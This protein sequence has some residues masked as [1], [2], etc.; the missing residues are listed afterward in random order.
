MAD[1]VYGQSDNMTVN[2]DGNNG[3]GEPG[4]PAPH[5]LSHP[6]GVAVDAGGRVYIAD[7]MHHRV[8]SY[9][10]GQTAAERVWGQG[11]KFGDGVTNNDGQG[12]SGRTGPDNFNPPQNLWIDPAG[13]LYVTDTGNS[14]TLVINTELR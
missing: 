9:A 4:A 7:S 6:K 5:N 14:R 8:L 2:T 11:G 1:R 10:P 3:K 13:M 12:Q